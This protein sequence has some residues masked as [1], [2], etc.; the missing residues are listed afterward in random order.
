MNSVSQKSLPLASQDE[1]VTPHY[2][3]GLKVEAQKLKKGIIDQL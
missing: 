2:I 3:L 1:N